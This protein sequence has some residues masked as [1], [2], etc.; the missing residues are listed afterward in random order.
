MSRGR[1]TSNEVTM[2]GMFLGEAD[3]ELPSVDRRVKRLAALMLEQGA[4]L[5]DVM[6]AMEGADNLA[7]EVFEDPNLSMVTEGRI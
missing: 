1:K 5:Q 3:Y 4:P 7:K 6:G 2:T